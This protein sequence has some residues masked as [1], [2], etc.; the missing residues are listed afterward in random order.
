ML[1]ELL[2]YMLSL[3]FK[4]G[5]SQCEAE[6]WLESPILKQTNFSDNFCFSGSNFFLDQHGLLRGSNSNLYLDIFRPCE[7]SH[8]VYLLNWGWLYLQKV[9]WEKRLPWICIWVLRHHSHLLTA[10]VS[11]EGLSP[12]R[13]PCILLSLVRLVPMYSLSP[14]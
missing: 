10:S 4:R 9:L 11:C 3:F 8:E 14:H 5:I 1:S 12:M 7:I 13:S 2:L 6:F